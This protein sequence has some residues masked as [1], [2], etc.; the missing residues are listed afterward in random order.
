MHCRRV[1]YARFID[2]SR[3]VVMPVSGRLWR[4][5]WRLAAHAFEVSI[6][7]TLVGRME[8]SRGRNNK[9]TPFYSRPYHV[10]VYLA[11]GEVAWPRSF[12]T[13]GEALEFIKNNQTVTNDRS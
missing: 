4:R 7:G 11:N 9:R 10:L 8:R 13:S 6:D 12:K 5:A 1:G 3:W 2:A